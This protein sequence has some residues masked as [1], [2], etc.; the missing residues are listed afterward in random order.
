MCSGNAIHMAAVKARALIVEAAANMME[1]SQADIELHDGAAWVKGT[2]RRATLAEIA[3]ATNP[4]RY[5][6]NK[7]SASATQFAPASRHDG[8]QLAEG[9]TPGIETTD[10]YSPPHA[11]WAF[12]AHAA[13]IEVDPE[14]CT[15]DV[16]RYVCIHD[17]GR[18]INPMIVDG[19]VMG[20]IAQGVGGAFYER[21]EFD[22]EG[23]PLNANF[24][25]FLIPYATEVPTRRSFTRRR[26]LR[27]TRWAS[28]VW[29]KP[30]PFRWRRF[31]RQRWKMPCNP[32]GSRRSARRR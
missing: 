10:Y 5:A 15:V 13:V 20:G 4:L 22:E 1:C 18:M 17:C 24:M 25:D 27:S 3:T 32:S 29:A 14:L 12:G 9:R 31:T 21:C 28:R 19:Q 11:T 23:T 6:F 2:D 30:A 26:P 16:K 8:P 7:P